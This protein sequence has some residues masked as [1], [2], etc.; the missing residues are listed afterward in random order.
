MDGL[1]DQSVH[2]DGG[3]RTIVSIGLFDHISCNLAAGIRVAKHR[4][5]DLL[6]MLIDVACSSTTGC[7]LT[8]RVSPIDASACSPS[9]LSG[10]QEGDGQ[11][12]PGETA[13]QPAPRDRPAAT[14]AGQRG[15]VMSIPMP[16]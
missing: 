9:Q 13:G 5:A 16:A 2:P 3:M 12:H 4:A 10:S 8:R 15:H 11:V 14:G 7:S 6:S 1:L